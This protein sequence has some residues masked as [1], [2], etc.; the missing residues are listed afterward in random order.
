MQVTLQEEKKKKSLLSVQ[1]FLLELSEE[2]AQ[3]TVLSVLQRPQKGF[4][5][6]VG[7]TENS[8]TASL[9]LGSG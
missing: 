9:V 6:Q 7:G 4:D 1:L 3:G 5:A 8:L 2:D